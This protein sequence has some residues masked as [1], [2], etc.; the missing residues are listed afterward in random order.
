MPIFD[1]HADSLVKAFDNSYSLKDSPKLQ[2]NLDKIICQKYF[3]QC[4]AVFVNDNIE[5]PFEYYKKV[6]NYYKQYINNRKINQISKNN[7]FKSNKVN[8]LCL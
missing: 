3:C 7:T 2:V 1:L 6:V 4:F 5:K 8:A